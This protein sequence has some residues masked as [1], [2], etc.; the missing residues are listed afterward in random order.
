MYDGGEV[1]INYC[2]DDLNIG[3]AAVPHESIGLLCCCYWER[4]V[5]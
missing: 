4:L 2:A 1:K 3:W 5:I